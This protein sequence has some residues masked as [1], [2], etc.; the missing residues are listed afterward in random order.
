MQDWNRP[1]LVLVGRI[2]DQL[3]ESLAIASQPGRFVFFVLTAESRSR[4]KP[5]RV[6]D[7]DGCE[8]SLVGGF[9]LSCAVVTS[10]GG[11]RGRRLEHGVD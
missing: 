6:I 9:A 3:S 8:L 5:D 10:P 1:F 4:I 11:P 7:D 2:F